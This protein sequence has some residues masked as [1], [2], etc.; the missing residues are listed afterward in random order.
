M[1]PLDRPEFLDHVRRGQWYYFGN[2]LN[3]YDW[4]FDWNKFIDLLDTHPQKKIEHDHRK[5]KYAL[6]SLERRESAPKC[7]H[8][9]CKDLRRV[10]P[11]NMISCIAFQGFTK[12]HESFKIHKDVMDVL[13]VQSVGSIDMSVWKWI[14]GPYRPERQKNVKMVGRGPANITNKH[15]DKIEMLFKKTFTRGDA[16]WL[17]RG[18][19]HFIEPHGSRIGLSFGVESDPNPM[20]YIRP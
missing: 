20:D 13:Y 14:G 6:A 16:I 3:D 4:S 11:K 1:T 18:T 5:M 17:P 15:K 8:D 7:V 2:L 19:Y 12:D 10:F 9:F